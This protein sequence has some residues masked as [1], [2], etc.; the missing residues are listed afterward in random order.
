MR[1]V[2]IDLF[3]LVRASPERFAESDGNAHMACHT[4]TTQPAVCSRMHRQDGI[5]YL[6]G[7][8]GVFSF[9]VQ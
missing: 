5:E 7:A 6:D 1:K 8:N 4:C 9:L 3:S 2:L